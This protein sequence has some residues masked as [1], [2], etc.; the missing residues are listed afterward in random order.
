[1]KDIKEM[2]QFELKRLELLIARAMYT[3]RRLIRIDKSTPRSDGKTDLRVLYRGQ[4]PYRVTT[5]GVKVY[6]ILRE[7]RKV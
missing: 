1:M 2:N 5:D 4:F 7:I 3:Q 6:S